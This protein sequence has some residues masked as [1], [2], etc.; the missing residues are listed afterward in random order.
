[1]ADDDVRT[2]PVDDLVD[3]AAGR[4]REGVD[5]MPQGA[6]R[7]TALASVERPED[8][9]YR[10]R[11]RVVG[12]SSARPQ[13][14]VVDLETRVLKLL[15]E[16]ADDAFGTAVPCGRHKRRQLQDDL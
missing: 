1:M 10:V 12:T 16:R 6:Q 8:V 5:G 2:Q 15:P 11:R 3:D 14:A 4:Q 9:S 13:T 7:G